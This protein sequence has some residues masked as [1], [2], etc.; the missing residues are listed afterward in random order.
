M[1]AFVIIFVR[2]HLPESPRWQIMHGRQE[3]AEG[4][5]AE[6]EEDVG[7]TKGELPPVDPSRELEIRPTEQIGYLPLLKTL[8]QHYPSRSIYGATLMITQSFLYNAIFFTLRAGPARTSTASAPATPA[9]TCFMAV[10]RPATCSARSS[11]GR[12]FDSHRPPA[13]DRR[14]PTCSSG[15]LLLIAAQRL[16]I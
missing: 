2:R 15:V 4:S 3:Q 10:L 14:S 7:K 6:I 13:D 16:S 9:R 12:L 5:I 11:I 1:L 8:F